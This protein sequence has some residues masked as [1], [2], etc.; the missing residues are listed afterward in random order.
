MTKKTKIKNA[1]KNI[2]NRRANSKT[3]NKTFWGRVWNVICVPFRFIA[4]VCRKRAWRS[5]G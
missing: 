1:A 5:V 4:K 3:Q 2:N